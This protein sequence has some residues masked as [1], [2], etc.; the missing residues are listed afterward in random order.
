MVDGAPVRIAT[1]GMGIAVTEAAQGIPVQIATNGLGIPIV[2]KLS[3]GLPVKFVGAGGNLWV[4]P[5]IAGANTTMTIA[6]GRVRATR[7]GGNPRVYKAISGLTN[8][9][10]YKLSGGSCFAGTQ[11]G[12]MI[13]RQSTSV[14]IPDGDMFS[15][16]ATFPI[17]FNFVA[18]A[19]TLYIGMVV[20]AD[21]DGQYAEITD[22]LSLVLVP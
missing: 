2:V 17:D 21:T 4:G 6:G 20:I 5:W 19:T 9:A 11:S 13:L 12:N 10:T 14:G 15:G 1:N 7:A 22:A 16:A 3:G 8:G 18:T